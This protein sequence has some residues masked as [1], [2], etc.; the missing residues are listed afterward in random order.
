M[1]VAGGCD[2]YP[3]SATSS[4]AFSFNVTDLR[5]AGEGDLLAQI[6]RLRKQ[7]DAEGLL[8]RQ[9]RLALPVAARARSASSPARAAR[10]A[11]TCSRRSRG[12]AGRGGIVWAFAPVQDRHAAP[13]IARALGDLAAL[14]DVEVVIVARGGGSL[15]DLLCFCDETLCR[16]VALLAVPV[17]ASVG[18]PHRPHAARRRRRGELLDPHPR[19]RGGRAPST[20]RAARR[21]QLA[22]GRAPARARP[23]RVLA[24]R[25]RQLALAPRACATTAAGRCSRGRGGSRCSRARPAR[26]SSASATRLHQQL[27]EIRAGSRRRLRDGAERTGTRALVLAR[28]AGST[29]LDCRERRPRELERLALALGGPRPAAHARAR[30]RAR[31]ATATGGRRQR[32]RARRAGGGELRLRFADGERRRARSTER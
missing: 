21:E 13:A 25:E 8:E 7:L 14:G 20:A 16:T 5:I 17:I 1:V 24:E 11:T 32:R 10:R 28:K 3:G 30:L 4:P 18:P 27:R 29:L 19:R 26:T 22:A 2:Y 31:P 23:Q 9:K 12:A 15:A 6:D